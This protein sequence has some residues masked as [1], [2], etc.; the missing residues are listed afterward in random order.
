MPWPKLWPFTRRRSDTAAL[1]AG[2]PPAEPKASA[3][4]DVGWVNHRTGLGMSGLDPALAA[5]FLAGSISDEQAIEL[6]RGDPIARKVVHKPVDQ[7]M[8]PGFDLVIKESADGRDTKG[9]RSGDDQRPALKLERDVRARWKALKVFPAVRKAW[10][11]ARREGGAAIL[12]GSPDAA[13]MAAPLGRTGRVDIRWLR[14]LR[15]RDLWPARYYSNPRGEK[16]DEP[17]LWAV[18]TASKFGSGGGLPQ[19]PVHESRLWIF[20]GETV[21]DEPYPGQLH[22]GFGDS[23]LLR[24]FRVLRRYGSACAGVEAL[25][26]KFGE[27]VLQ[28]EGLASMLA[29]DK[30]GE[31]R[32]A[33]EAVEYIA[34]IYRVR[35]VDA[36]DKF[37]REAPSVAGVAD[38]LA[39]VARELAA[40]ADMPVTEIFGDV[41]GGIGDN[42]QG[43][44]LAWF[45][46]V[47][48]LRDE[49]AVP[50]ITWLTELIMRGLGRGQLPDDW[51]VV[52][53]PLWQASAKEQADTEKVEADIDSAYLDRGVVTPAMVMRRAAVVK[54]YSI[55]VTELDALEEALQEVPDD[56]RTRG[57]RPSGE[58]E[59]ADEEPD[60]PN[61]GEDPPEPGA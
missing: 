17:E 61:E 51:E 7:A 13:D 59:P 57:E 55:D 46:V 22:P 40:A 4:R 18:N 54:R 25:L 53:R 41:V 36:Q 33:I 5:V 38:L 24:F 15:A 26:S 11:W 8:R 52:G 56:V 32:A 27:P 50:P 60:D 47:A 1:P 43:P 37:S 23:V 28:M 14:V 16:F 39:N 2:D 45:D 12:V 34:S 29:K 31:I 44:K 6:E 9:R 19:M 35:L 49:H 42:S 10:K 21:T 30:A 48:G 58:V 20:P 3:R